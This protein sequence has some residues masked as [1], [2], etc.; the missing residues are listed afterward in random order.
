VSEGSSRAS[1]GPPGHADISLL[2]P[3][4]QPLSGEQ[5]A[6]AVALLSDLLLAVARRAHSR[7][8][9]DVDDELREKGLAA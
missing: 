3:H 9:R 4:L 2:P 8:L 1:S 5:L 7:D 6:E